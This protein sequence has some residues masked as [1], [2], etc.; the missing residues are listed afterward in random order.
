MVFVEEGA[1]HEQVYLHPVAA[2]PRSFWNFLEVP[3]WNVEV[4]LQPCTSQEDEPMLKCFIRFWK[5]G[6]PWRRDLEEFSQEFLRPLIISRAA[7]A[8]LQ[9][10]F[11]NLNY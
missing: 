9:A 11:L 1:G 5:C 2:L 3:G 10:N 4:H 6:L 7:E 8:G